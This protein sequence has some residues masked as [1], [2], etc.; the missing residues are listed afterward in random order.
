VAGEN[1]TNTASVATTAAPIGPS[2]TTV[3]L[4][5]FTGFPGVPFWGE[6][7]KGTTA[8]EL[9]RV[10][11][12]AGSVIT[13]TRGQGGLSA[14][15][16]GAGVTFEL[17]APADFYTRCETHMAATNAHGV[18]GSVVGTSGAQTV[19][20]K[21]FRGAFRSDYTDALPVGIT[22]SFESNANSASARDGFVHN[23]TA[24]DAAR[25]AFLAKQSGTDRFRVSNTGNVTISPS[26]GTALTV[27]GNETVSGTLGVTGATTLSGGV[28]TTTVTASGTVS[29]GTLTSAGSINGLSL[30]VLGTVHAD[31]ALDTDSTL[32]VDGAST[33]T[34]AVTMGNALT[35]TRGIGA[36]SG[37]VPVAVSSTASVTSPTL[38]DIVLDTSVYLWKVWN[39]STWITIN[40]RPTQATDD[41]TLSTTSTS[42]T[43][44]MTGGTVL[45]FSFTAPPSGQVWVHNTAFVDNTGT[46]RS[47]QSWIIRNGSTVGSGTTFQDAGDEKSLTNLGA[48][49]VSATRTRLVTGL[50]PGN[51]YNIRHQYRVS[52]STGQFLWRELIVEPVA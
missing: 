36:W 13:M 29:G 1:Y 22:A 40:P 47:Y 49:D 51:S 4:A 30:S 9:V 18:T 34:G 6:F 39:G 5:N 21:N 14:T 7:E 35:V 20:D 37:R 32:T 8:A 44:T 11:N 50:T 23:N 52:G 2:D 33:L 42:F 25:A 41:A 12:V 24:G 26:T 28:S 17:V 48:D 16:H 31:G 19:A 10:T 27:T 3:T 45:G 38:G 43:E 46:A 15:S